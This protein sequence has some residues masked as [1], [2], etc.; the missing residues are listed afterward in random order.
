MPNANLIICTHPVVLHKIAQLRDEATTPQEFRRLSYEISLF[1][2]Y[3]ATRQLLTKEDEVETPLMKTEVKVIDAQP[4]LVPIL[5]AGLCMV[6]AMLLILPEAA[7]GHVGLFRDHDT[8]EPV[9]YYV[10]LPRDLS[11]WSC[12][13]LDP[14]LATGGSVS[15]T[16]KLLK[17]RGAEH[18]TLISLVAAPEGVA[19]MLDAHPD[20][21]VVI[22][23]LDEKLNTSGYILPGL[24]DAGDRLY[25]TV[26]FSERLV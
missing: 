11:G 9:E 3:E 16:I 6:D 7:V 1:L 12:F 20:V 23:V 22:G 14:M 17:Q 4:M 19:R 25:R 15:H 2:G 21:S 13:I 10:K 18:I 24:G 5:R 8:L 26:S